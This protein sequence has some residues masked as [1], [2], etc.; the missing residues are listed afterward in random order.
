MNRHVARA[1]RAEEVMGPLSEVLTSWESAGGRAPP[2]GLTCEEP[3]FVSQ[4]FG[5][6]LDMDV[7]MSAFAD[8]FSSSADLA[9]AH[10]SQSLL[11]FMNGQDVYTESE[12]EDDAPIFNDFTTGKCLLT[13]L[14]P[15]AQVLMFL[16]D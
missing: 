16:T 8:D 9:R 13:C 15:S 2:T 5:S 12:P 7:I 3:S 6:D 4:N 1:S 14:L 11:D 10:M